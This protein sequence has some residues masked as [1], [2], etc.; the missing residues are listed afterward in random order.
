MSI[1]LLLGD[2]RKCPDDSSCVE[3]LH[4]MHTVNFDVIHHLGTLDD[5]EVVLPQR[6]TAVQVLRV[7]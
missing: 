6:H 7:L 3:S 2:D 1:L 4:V 5:V